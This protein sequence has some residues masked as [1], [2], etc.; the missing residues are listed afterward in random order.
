MV[1]VIVIGF[2]CVCWII[3]EECLLTSTMKLSL[4]I[5]ALGIYNDYYNEWINHER[6]LKTLKER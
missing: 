1:L 5:L 6:M 4:K 3:Y 2:G